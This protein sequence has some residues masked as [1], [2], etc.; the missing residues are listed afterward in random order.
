[1]HRDWP[2]S[3]P[4]EAR[5][6]EA[7]TSRIETLLAVTDHRK[8]LEDNPFL[9][10]SPWHCLATSW[11]RRNNA[12]RAVRAALAIHGVGRIEPQELRHALE[13]RALQSL[14]TS[15]DTR[16]GFAALL[17]RIENKWRARR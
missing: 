6:V 14:T 13:P 15:I 8:L 1:L 16:Q 17:D 5:Y 3:G 11:H 10:R 12:V 2:R 7:K 4:A 9:D